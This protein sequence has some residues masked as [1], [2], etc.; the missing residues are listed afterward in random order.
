MVDL[1][2]NTSDDEEERMRKKKEKKKKY[3]DDLFSPIQEAN[4][5]DED[6]EKKVGASNKK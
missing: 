4:D 1:S 3:K 5:E 6:F 2:H